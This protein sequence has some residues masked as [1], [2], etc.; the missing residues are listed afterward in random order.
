MIKKDKKQ[1]IEELWKIRREEKFTSWEEV[2]KKLL[3]TI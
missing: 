1:L 3:A 2:K